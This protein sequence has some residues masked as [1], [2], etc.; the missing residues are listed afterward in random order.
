VCGGACTNV[1]NNREHCGRCNNRCGGDLVCNGTSCGCPG[2]RRV[3]PNNPN[4]CVTSLNECCPGGQSWCANI[5]DNGGCTNLKTDRNHCNSCTTVCPGMDVCTNGA[6]I[7]PS[8]LKD[9][10]GG[11]CIQ[12]GTCCPG[13]EQACGDKCIPSADCCDDTECMVVGQKCN[14]ATNKCGCAADERVCMRTGTPAKCIKMTGTCCNDGD[15]GGGG[16]VCRADNTCGCP[17]NRP[18]VC[19]NTCIAADACC[20]PQV[21]CPTTGK[22]V[23]PTELS[24][25]CGTCPA[26][27]QTCTA[28]GRCACPGN[29]TVCEG[30]CIPPGG[31]CG[32]CPGNRV[33]NAQNMCECPAGE[34]GNLCCPAGQTCITSGPGG[35]RCGIPPLPD[36]TIPPGGQPP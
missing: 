34:C 15:C 30:K 19:G 14:L 35:P 21:K 7:C 20:A 25:C 24:T 36:P 32:S 1:R 31:C 33:C 26:M 17:E 8:T 23:A 11:V 29:Q 13:R 18:Q 4:K 10:N 3:C 2:G 6:C 16:R 22:C 9:C 5:G 27:G 28:A 12:P